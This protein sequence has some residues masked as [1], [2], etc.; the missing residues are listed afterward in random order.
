MTS[1]RVGAPVALAARHGGWSPITP[2]VA[3]ERP[4]SLT[5]ASGTLRI[6]MGKFP[7]FTARRS[8]ANAAFKPSQGLSPIGALRA[9]YR[10][11]PAGRMEAQA[12]LS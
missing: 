11:R 5:K 3:M 7:I 6:V 9:R 2:P 12:Y 1:K 8:R 4:P 10:R